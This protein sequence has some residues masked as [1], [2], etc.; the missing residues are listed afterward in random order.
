VRWSEHEAAKPYARPLGVSFLDEDG[1]SLGSL[2]V[3]GPELLYY[4]HFQAATLALAG[5]LFRDP[6]IEAAPDPQRAWLDLLA[7]LMP[8]ADLSAVTPTSDFD[9]AVGRVFRFQ[10]SCDGGRPLLVEAA[11]LMSYQ[12]LQAAIAH[13]SGSLFRVAGVEA[14]AGPDERQ[15]AWVGHLRDR[16][17]RPDPSEAISIS[18]PWR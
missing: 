6:G 11:H 10:L 8:P 15:A 18:W 13:Q 5:E 9:P 2:A 1:L 12:D 16:L 4:G 17:R 14:I 3:N 7:R